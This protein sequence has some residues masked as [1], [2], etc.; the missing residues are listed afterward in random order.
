MRVTNITLFITLENNID[1][2]VRF[3]I[4]CTGGGIL[5]VGSCQIDTLYYRLLIR[6]VKNNSKTF[7]DRRVKWQKDRH[8]F[9]FEMFFLEKTLVDLIDWRECWIIKDYGCQI[10]FASIICLDFSNTFFIRLLDI[11][12]ILNN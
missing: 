4:L 8:C 6:L 11:L 10:I 7:S 9:P 1:L 12:F 3:N 2:S 5:R